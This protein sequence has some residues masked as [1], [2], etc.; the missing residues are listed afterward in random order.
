V[1]ADVATAATGLD[2]ADQWVA[3]YQSM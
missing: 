1:D 2:P 3:R